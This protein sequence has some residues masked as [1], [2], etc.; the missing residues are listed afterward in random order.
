MANI[1]T[2]LQGMQ[3]PTE[4]EIEE[5]ETPEVV[6]PAE[7]D[8]PETDEPTESIVKEEQPTDEVTN[9]TEEIV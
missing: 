2:K 5:P 4:P 7:P 6:E 9:D 8:V 3:V 1:L